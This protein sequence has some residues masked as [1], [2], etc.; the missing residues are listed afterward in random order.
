MI[1][2][3]ALLAAPL[4]LAACTSL[5]PDY[6]APALPVPPTMGAAQPLITALSLQLGALAPSSTVTEAFTWSTTLLMLGLGLGMWAGGALVQ[7]R[8]DVPRYLGQPLYA[9]GWNDGYRQCQALLQARSGLAER[10]GNALERQRDR[11]RRHHVDQA[12]AQ[13]LHRCR[14]QRRPGIQEAG[15]VRRTASVS[16]PGARPRTIDRSSRQRR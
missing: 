2:R 8:K 6:Q 1:P 4:A 5:A 11:E 9:E 13:A 14:G 7:F 16:A 15:S 3:R 12:K 10:R